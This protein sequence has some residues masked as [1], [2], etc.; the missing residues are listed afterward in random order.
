MLQHL[1][2]LASVRELT[3]AYL[4]A[5]RANDLV[6]SELFRIELC[7]RLVSVCDAIADSEGST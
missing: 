1:P 5:Q 6:L 7:R 3:Q 4:E 2:L